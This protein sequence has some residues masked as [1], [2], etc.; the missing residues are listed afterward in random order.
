[1][2]CFAEW[3][4]QINMQVSGDRLG[5]IIGRGGNTLRQLEAKVTLRGERCWAKVSVISWKL[6]HI[7]LVPCQDRTIGSALQRR[8]PIARACLVWGA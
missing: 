8:G 2:R 5:L 7:V 6:A 4:S 3:L 1:M